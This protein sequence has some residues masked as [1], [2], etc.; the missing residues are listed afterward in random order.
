[1]SGSS[2]EK[3]K[4]VKQVSRNEIVFGLAR[5]P[6]TGHI[7]FGGSEFSVWDVDLDREKPEPKELGR[8]ESYVTSLALAGTTLVSGSYDGRLIWWNTESGSQVRSVA[9]HQKWI[10]CVRATP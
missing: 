4:V 5:K 1:M 9:A 6:R 7:Y 3:I 10:R 8:H 2:P